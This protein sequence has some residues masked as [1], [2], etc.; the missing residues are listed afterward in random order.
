MKDEISDYQVASQE[1]V[2]AENEE[3]RYDFTNPS[4]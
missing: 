4:I 2:C 1:R 3:S